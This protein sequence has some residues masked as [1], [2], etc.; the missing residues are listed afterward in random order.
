[1]S[2]PPI[3]P[4]GIVLAAGA[5]FRYGTPKALVHDDAGTPWLALATRT[6]LAA[7]CDPILV[8]LGAAPEAAALVPADERMSVLVAADWRRGLHASLRTALAAA[9]ELPDPLPQAALITLVDL[10]GLPLAAAL[11][12]SHGHEGDP[13]ALRR[14]GYGGRPGH[15]V[16]IGRDHWRPLADSLADGPDSDAG[17]RD[18]IEAH[19]GVL[20]DCGDLWDGRDIDRPA[21]PDPTG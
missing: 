5:G 13:G 20:V 12:V 16:L 14:A 7:G 18:Y 1:M 17:A 15:P 19:G 9:L 8:V 3:P 21:Q 11:R 4:V 10:P 6:L 2:Q